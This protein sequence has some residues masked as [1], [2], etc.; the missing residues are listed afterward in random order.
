MP[1]T[2]ELGTPE[3]IGTDRQ[4]IGMCTRCSGILLRR[5]IVLRT[6]DR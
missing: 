4:R 6:G 2:F 5:A 1:C 3:A